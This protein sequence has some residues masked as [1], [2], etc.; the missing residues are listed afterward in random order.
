MDRNR[1]SRLPRNS[2]HAPLSTPHAADSLMTDDY[3]RELDLI[4]ACVEE[5]PICRIF[6]VRVFCGNN[7]GTVLGRYATFG[8][9][10]YSS[11]KLTLDRQKL[12]CLAPRLAVLCVW[13]LATS[14]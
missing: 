4:A 7:C 14:A 5:R 2:L 9:G 1:S 11:M 8:C 12:H 10:V 6:M 3:G 13:A